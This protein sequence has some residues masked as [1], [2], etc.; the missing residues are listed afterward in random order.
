[1]TFA[2]R[3]CA[4][5]IAG[6]SNRSYREIVISHGADLAY[7]EMVSS[8]ALVFGNVKTR[9]LMDIE[10]EASPKLV[11]I[12]G[13]EPQHVLR[14]AQCAVELGADMLDLNM[15]CPAPKVVRNNEGSMLMRNPHLA[16]ELVRVA[17]QAGVPVSCKIRAGWDEESRNAV[18]FARYLEDAGAAFVAV[19]GRTRQQF[20]SGRADWSI[21]AAVKRALSIPVIGNGDIFTAEDALQMFDQTGCDGVMVGRGMLGNPWIF[22]DIQ[23]ALAGNTP[24]GRPQAAQIATQAL[25][26][27]QQHIR[28][29]VYWYCQREGDSPQHRLIAEELAVRALRG[30]LGWY[31]KGLRNAAR[32]RLRINAATSYAEVE[33]LFAEY[34]QQAD[35]EALAEDKV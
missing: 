11:Q 9:E 14:A 7:G 19:H 3:V 13:S 23:A 34:V 30:H 2:Y 29:S 25:A 18:E 22:A 6:I 16:A 24:P 28:R 31:S 4:A 1:M 8:R 15:G 10:G 33:Q 17:R 32:L 5:P 20:Y 21:V 27:L 26:H 35:S 12:S